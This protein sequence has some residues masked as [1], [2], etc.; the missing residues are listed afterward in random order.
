M[1]GFLSEA[2]KVI[3]PAAEEPTEADTPDDRS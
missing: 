3:A 1:A 2:I